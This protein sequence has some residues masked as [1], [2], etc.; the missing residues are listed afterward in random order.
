MNMTTTGET[1]ALA[2]ANTSSTALVLNN[3][4]M[5]R[6]F[7]M[8]E[9][10]ANGR[11]TVP[12]HLQGSVADCMAVTLQALQW[13]MSPFAVAQ[14]THLVNGA[15]GYEAQ[16]VNAVL[17]STGAIN[18]DFS[19][20]Y[21]GSGDSLE[22]RV[23]AIP[24]GKVTLVWGE[25]LSLSA[26]T[27]KNSPLWKTNPKQQIGYLQV[28]NWARQYKP[29]AILGVYT[30]D[31]LQGAEMHMGQAQVVN[32]QPAAP[33]EYPQADFDANLNKWAKL[34]ASGR[35]SFDDIVNTVEAKAPLSDDQ[36]SALAEAIKTLQ[37]NTVDATPKAA[38]NPEPA[39]E[40][41]SDVDA[42][43]RRLRSAPNLDVLFEAADLISN[44][45]KESQDSL[46]Q[47]FE[48][49]QAELGG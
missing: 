34:V 16:L 28:K 40:E 1:S 8:A 44:A 36:K 12:K 27:T 47:L 13:N 3:D 33:T 41:I 4:A 37:A 11:A 23:G 38:P 5:D 42:L 15:L 45:P 10:M 2:V 29:G 24:R 14:K 30:A 20:E 25:W 39:G 43:E 35:K 9:L 48:A 22:C 19:Y 46:S 49:R 6:A 18:G 7:R 31:E 32:A 26:I 21:K 17:Q